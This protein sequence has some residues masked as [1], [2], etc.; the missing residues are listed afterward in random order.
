MSRWRS[1]GG[2]VRASIAGSIAPRGRRYVIT[3]DAL[4]GQSAGPGPG[5]NRGGHQ[6]RGVARAWQDRDPAPT[7]ARRAVPVH[8]EVQRACRTG[9]HRVPQ[10]VA[11][12]RIGPGASRQRELP[13][14]GLALRARGSNRP[15]VRGRLRGA[16]SGADQLRLFPGSRVHGRHAYVRPSRAHNGRREVQHRG[17]GTTRA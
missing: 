17:A 6:D 1:A 8:R 7:E 12:L 9:H 3:L 10:H 15:A 14:S 11:S 2:G 4:D 5:A 16:G 13:G